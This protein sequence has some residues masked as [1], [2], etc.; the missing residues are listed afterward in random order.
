MKQNNRNNQPTR[1][2]DLQNRIL[3]IGA[4]EVGT[5]MH[6]ER[7]II[8]HGIPGEEYFSKTRTSPRNFKAA[9]TSDPQSRAS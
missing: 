9:F 2:S 4:V 8:A 7:Q 6:E 5:E 1:N 3:K